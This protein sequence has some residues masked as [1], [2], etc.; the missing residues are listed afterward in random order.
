MLRW[1]LYGQN[2]PNILAYAFLTAFG[3]PATTS[4]FGAP[5]STA[6]AFGTPATSTTSGF[7][8]GNLS[9]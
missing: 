3:Q 6:S 5:A 9:L 4:A 7:G 2:A 8:S 1:Q